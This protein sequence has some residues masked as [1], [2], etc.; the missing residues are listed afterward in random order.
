M[1]NQTGTQSDTH[2][3]ESL[4]RHFDCLNILEIGCGLYPLSKLPGYT[5][6]DFSETVTSNLPVLNVDI[7]QELPF[8]DKSFDCFL[9]RNVLLHIPHDKIG[10]TV[11][12]LRRV[13]QKVGFIQEPEPFKETQ[14]HCFSHNLKELFAE[15]P[16]VNI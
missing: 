15:F 12:E 13:T 16:L 5:G 11:S 7:T 14:P 3:I 8:C 4:M 9:S 1:P 10:V 6:I 2:K